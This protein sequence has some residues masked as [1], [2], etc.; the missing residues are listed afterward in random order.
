[1]RSLTLPPGLR[2]SSF[3]NRRPRRPARLAS[4]S[5]SPSGVAPTVWATLDRIVLDKDLGLLDVTE[6]AVAFGNA[7]LLALVL[8]HL[9]DQRLAVGEREM[10]LDLPTNANEPRHARAG[11]CGRAFFGRNAGGG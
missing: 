6:H 10:H 5:S 11:D 1:M 7:H 8:G 4:R 2:L 3:A 9:H